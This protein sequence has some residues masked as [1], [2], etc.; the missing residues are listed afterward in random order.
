MKEGIGINN[1][2]F[3]NIYLVVKRK[4]L[5]FLSFIFGEV[6]IIFSF[7]HKFAKE[8]YVP[9]LHFYHVLIYVYTFSM[10]YIYTIYLL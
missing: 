4:Y 2:D 5:L 10:I 8:V 6:F 7:N 3:L 1:I 9:F